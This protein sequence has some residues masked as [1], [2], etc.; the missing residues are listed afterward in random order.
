MTD[1]DWDLVQRVHLRGSYKVTKAAWPIF[2]E[3]KYGR[4]VMTASAAGIYGNYGQSSYSA[5]KL[6]LAG[7]AFSLAREGAKS[8]ILVNTIA[9]LAASRMTESILPPEMLDALKPDFIAP[10]V[11][12][13]CHESNKETGGLF[14]V[15]AG[16]VGKLRWERSQ[17]VL[18]K[19][20]TSLTPGAIANVFPK[21]SDFKGAEYP[22]SIVEKDWIGL[23]EKGKELPANAAPNKLRFDGKVAIVTGAGAG[24]GKAYALAFAR[25]GGMSTMYINIIKDSIFHI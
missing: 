24:L 16:Y 13:L 4:V 21:V 1:Q 10:L 25:D 15:G 20:D 11:A 19:C 7:F 3:Q 5:A 9:P 17:G 6:G 14:E 18:L 23:V 2:L 8:N 12:F 22:E